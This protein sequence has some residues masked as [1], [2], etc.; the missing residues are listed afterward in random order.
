MLL[1][2][3]IGLAS[4]RRCVT[5]VALTALNSHDSKPARHIVHADLVPDLPFSLVTAGL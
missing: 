1:L 3:N 2:E 4:F 5:R